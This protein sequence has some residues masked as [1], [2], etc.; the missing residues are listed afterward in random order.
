MQIRYLDLS[1]NRQTRVFIGES[2]KTGYPAL[3]DCILKVASAKICLT[4][5]TRDQGRVA[6]P[7]RAGPEVLQRHWGILVDLTA[8]RGATAGNPN[9]TGRPQPGP[10]VAAHAMLPV[11]SCLDGHDRG[12]RASRRSPQHAG[13]LRRFQ[14]SANSTWNVEE[15]ER[16]REVVHEVLQIGHGVLII[17]LFDRDGPPLRP[18]LRFGSAPPQLPRPRLPVAI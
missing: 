7:P 4:P 11:S 8:K 14:P 12:V 15:P 5:P 10:G 3:V 2:A 18:D 1:K 17:P 16:G 6:R 9:A 13:H